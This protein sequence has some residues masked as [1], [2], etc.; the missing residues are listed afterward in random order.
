MSPDDPQPQRG[1][2]S[3]PKPMLDANDGAGLSRSQKKKQYQ[4][5]KQRAKK[6]ASVHKIVGRKKE[7]DSVAKQ[8]SQAW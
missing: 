8:R 6:M 1:F 4:E 3:K 7:K 5:L 2:G